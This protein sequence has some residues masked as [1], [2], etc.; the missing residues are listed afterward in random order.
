MHVEMVPYVSLP[1]AHPRHIV[2]D[3][4]F[5]CYSTV[6]PAPPGRDTT[7]APRTKTTAKKPPQP[8]TSASASERDTGDTG[9]DL[10]VESSQDVSPFMLPP[11]IS[12]L[13]SITTVNGHVSDM[14]HNGEDNGNSPTGPSAA[15]D[16]SIYG[17]FPL[18][19]PLSPP[20]SAS[21]IP[22]PMSGMSAESEHD[23]GNN[24]TSP[25]RPQETPIYGMFALSPPEYSPISD[26]GVSETSW[27]TVDTREHASN[28]PSDA[29]KSTPAL[30]P[31]SEMHAKLP[32]SSLSAATARKSAKRTQNSRRW[33]AAAPGEP[34]YRTKPSPGTVRGR[35][36]YSAPSVPG[37]SR[38][39]PYSILGDQLGG[40]EA[41]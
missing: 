18:P 33:S 13:A 19:P 20:S 34:Y 17:M 31:P 2:S 14:E 37:R 36:H 30:T 32:K 9:S 26:A 1:P 22:T 8:A 6:R 29:P 15:P 39:N 21:N 23:G 27:E 28:S 12:P 38:E 16:G 40:D 25:E 35:L 4:Q 3:M 11:A 5:V 10:S 7:S 41:S 24:V